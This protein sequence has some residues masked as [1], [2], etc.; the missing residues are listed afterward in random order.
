MRITAITP[1]GDR[2]QAFALCERWMQRQT[3]P[4]DQWIVVDDGELDDTRVTCGQ[5]L[6]R[7]H[8]QGTRPGDLL[9]ANLRTVWRSGV[10]A[11]DAVAFVEDDDWY[12]R[13][14]LA[15]TVRRL[16][17]GA[18][19]VGQIP[20][21]TWHFAKRLCDT[22]V[23]W[24]YLSTLSRTAMTMGAVHSFPSHLWGADTVFL[25]GMLWQHFGSRG[26]RLFDAAGDECVVGMKA[27]PGRTGLTRT[28][29]GEGDHWK[30]D[31]DGAVLRSWVGDDA[32]IYLNL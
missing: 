17:E 14:Y 9:L 5:T 11:G 13:D 21:R 6:I 32:D 12:G 18:P 25:D 1:T 2:P 23:P 24:S 8:R 15:V 7:R 29:K 3:R 30:P 16:E 26:A 10:I 31:P 20:C 28:H 27:M 19:M 4:P 22:L